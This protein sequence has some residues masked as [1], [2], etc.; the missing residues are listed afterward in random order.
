M[1]PRRRKGNKETEDAPYQPQEQKPTEI[2]DNVEDLDDPSSSEEDNEDDP[3]V[4]SYDLFI[5]NQ[6]KDHIYLLQYPIR[7]PDEEYYAQSAP[8]NAR[9][10]PNEGSFDLD[11]P[12]DN[13]NYCISRGDKFS[14]SHLDSESRTFDRQRLSG[15]CQSNQANYFVGVF[16]GGA[17]SSVTRRSYVLEQM[18]LTPVKGTVQLRPNFNYYDTAVGGERRKK[19]QSE[20][21]PAKQPRAVHV[22]LVPRIN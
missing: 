10:K 15:K 20:D 13:R 1:P 7:N 5:S 17:N 16:N 4:K 19:F 11:V 21:G 8:Y 18:H 22:I 6:L 12:I 2:M 3:I 14:G 9:I